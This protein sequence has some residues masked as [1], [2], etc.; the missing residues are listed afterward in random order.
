[1]IKKIISDEI[2]NFVEDQTKILKAAK[3][4]YFVWS[5]PLYDYRS[6]AKLIKSLVHDN[7]SKEKVSKLIKTLFYND[8]LYTLEEVN[9]FEISLNYTFVSI[10]KEKLEEFIIKNFMRRLKQLRS[11]NI[12]SKIREIIRLI[13]DYDLQCKEFPSHKERKKYSD[14]KRYLK[15]QGKS[16]NAPAPADRYTKEYLR[17]SIISALNDRFTQVYRNGKLKPF[18]QVCAKKVKLIVEKELPLNIIK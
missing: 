10:D 11:K 15:K 1:M 3:V 13:Y 4:H 17:E 7:P 5:D 14:R 2:D 12:P 16:I 9:K 18:N 8:R 6:T